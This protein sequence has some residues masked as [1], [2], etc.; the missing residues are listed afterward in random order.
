M[1]ARKERGAGF[2]PAGPGGWQ[3]HGSCAIPSHSPFSGLCKAP[4]FPPTPSTT[5][6]LRLELFTQGFCFQE[7]DTRVAVTNTSNSNN[8]ECHSLQG[9]YHGPR[10]PLFN[11]LTS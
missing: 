8:S 9:A 11:P 5:Q 1:R 2:A 6:G 4:L 10:G 3:G 7:D